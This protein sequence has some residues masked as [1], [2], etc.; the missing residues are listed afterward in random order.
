MVMS[1]SCDQS[2]AKHARLWITTTSE[3]LVSQVMRNK[4]NGMTQNHRDTVS[5]LVKLYKTVDPVSWVGR[6][7]RGPRFRNLM[8]VPQ[9]YFARPHTSTIV[10]YLIQSG[11]V[12]ICPPFKYKNNRRGEIVLLIGDGIQSQPRDAV[13]GQ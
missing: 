9:E 5:T 4:G 11:S 1:V 3:R 10:H 13:L 2:N 7:V 6:S 12:V 8:R